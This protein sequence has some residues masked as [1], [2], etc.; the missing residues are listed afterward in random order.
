MNVELVES[1]ILTDDDELTEEPV[2]ETQPIAV[3]TEPV[4]H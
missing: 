2:V 1:D 4:Q 3:Q